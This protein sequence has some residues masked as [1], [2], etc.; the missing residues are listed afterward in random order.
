MPN[1]NTCVRKLFIGANNVIRRKMAEIA[2]IHFV[3]EKF[4]IIAAAVVVQKI[5]T[6]PTNYTTTKAI[7]IRQRESR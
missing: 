7:G 6:A 2:K 1:P 3:V 4:F 5:N